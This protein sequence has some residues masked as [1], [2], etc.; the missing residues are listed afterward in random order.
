M[1]CVCVAVCVAKNSLNLIIV[2]AELGGQLVTLQVLTQL[3]LNPDLLVQ[4]EYF[5]IY[6]TSNASSATL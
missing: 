4:E 2:A 1:Q 5:T 6:S 3:C